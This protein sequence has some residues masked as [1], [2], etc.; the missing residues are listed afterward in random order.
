MVAKSTAGDRGPWLDL[1]TRRSGEGRPVVLLHG[2]FG[3]GANL[4]ALARSLRDGYRVLAP[5]L[6]GHGRSPTQV[7]YDLSGMAA[8]LS[9]WLSREEVGKAHLVGHSLGGKIAMQLALEYPDQVRSLVVADI[10]PVSYPA[11]HD[12]VFAGLA[13]V[14]AANCQNRDEADALLRREI[15]DERVVQFLLGSLYRGDDRRYHWRMDVAGLQRDYAALSAAPG[16]VSATGAGSA[17]PGTGKASPGKTSPERFTRWSGEV[18]FIKGGA[19]DYIRDAHRDAITALFPAAQVKVIPDSG[20]WLHVEKPNVFNG[21][22]AR[23]LEA[24]S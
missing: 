10:A 11:R 20:H 19:S 3:S 21:I 23:F 8:T 7:R 16:E 1:Y 4:G 18:L 2:L 9:A 13:A 12:A 24:Q 22:V 6:P 17:H 5:D 15:S 14:D